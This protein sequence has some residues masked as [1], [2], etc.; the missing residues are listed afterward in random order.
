MV[1][2]STYQHGSLHLKEANKIPVLG[3][4][5]QENYKFEVSLGYIAR[6]R[7]GGSKGGKMGKIY[8][9]FR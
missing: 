7:E 6:E 4:W 5:K 9:A 2:D 1:Y 3:R 8:L